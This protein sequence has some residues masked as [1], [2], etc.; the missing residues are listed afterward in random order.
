M[1]RTVWGPWG[2]DDKDH[3][4]VHQA[5]LSHGAFAPLEINHT[6]HLPLLNI[7]NGSSS[8]QPLSFATVTAT[9]NEYLTL[10]HALA[11]SALPCAILHPSLSSA[12][13]SYDPTEIWYAVSAAA[14]ASTA[15]GNLDDY[16]AGL[17]GHY[18]QLLLSSLKSEQAMRPSWYKGFLCTQKA[19]VKRYLGDTCPFESDIE[20]HTSSKV[21]VMTVKDGIEGAKR[22]KKQ[23]AKKKVQV[24]TLEEDLRFFGTRV[25]KEGTVGKDDAK[26]W[27]FESVARVGGQVLRDFDREFGRLN[28]EIRDGVEVG[29]RAT[30][31]DMEEMEEEE[32][33]WNVE[34]IWAR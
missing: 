14:N 18:Q 25:R 2:Q 31:K 19:W 4:I 32:R 26:Q 16:Y 10:L 33:R 34:E 29:L 6:Q 3:T 30:D 28:C 7:P 15:L 13:S 27:Y 5:R 11:L 22:E 20:R 21:W 8:F 23:I 24:R 17:L 12:E 9:S 1:V